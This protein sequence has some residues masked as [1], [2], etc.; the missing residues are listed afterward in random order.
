MFDPPRQYG[1]IA[2]IVALL[3]PPVVAGVPSTPPPGRPGAVPG[4]QDT[5]HT[6]APSARDI[7]A[8]LSQP[9]PAKPHRAALSPM[10]VLRSVPGSPR[11]LDIASSDHDP[12]ASALLVDPVERLP[13][14]APATVAETEDQPIGVLPIACT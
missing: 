12:L 3:A 10:P 13:L 11:R 9:P 4:L 5:A 7:L 1:C 14:G 6:A 2:V 8:A